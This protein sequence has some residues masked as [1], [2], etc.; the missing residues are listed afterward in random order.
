MIQKEK[1]KG[2]RVAKAETIIKDFLMLYNFTKYCELNTLFH[3][4]ATRKQDFGSD[5]LNV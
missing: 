1:Y 5:C 3:F 4:S 2:Y